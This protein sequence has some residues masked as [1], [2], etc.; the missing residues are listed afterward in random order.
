MDKAFI[1]G[2]MKKELAN[3]AQAEIEEKSM[4]ILKRLTGM[5]EFIS[6]KNIFTYVSAGSEV[7]TSEI[8][9]TALGQE[10]A[11]YCPAIRDGKIVAGVFDGELVAGKFGIMEPKQ[12]TDRKDFDLIIVPGLAFDESGMRVG[13]GG[14]HF[15]RFLAE[16]SGKKVA[17]TFDFQVVDRIENEPHDV[18]VDVIITE[19][20]TIHAKKA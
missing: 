16:A 9:T 7:K 3:Q 15:D 20:R 1:R 19:K 17:L 11:V 6:A 8:I 13:R 5:D 10:K 2:K 4:E 12:T 18:A 14:G